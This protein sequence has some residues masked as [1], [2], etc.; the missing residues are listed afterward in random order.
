MENN[1]ANSCFVLI[2]AEDDNGS[3]W[4]FFDRC[5][6]IVFGCTKSARRRTHVGRIILPEKEFE[7]C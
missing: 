2:A 3:V 7:E 4:V 5:R 1:K 6:L